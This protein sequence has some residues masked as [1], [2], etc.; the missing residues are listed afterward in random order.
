MVPPL[1]V[2]DAWVCDRVEH[3]G[4]DVRC[5]DEGCYYEEE[6]HDEGEVEDED[7]RYEEAPMPG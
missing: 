7:G 1:V 2:G 3:I 6:A 4:Q 5:D